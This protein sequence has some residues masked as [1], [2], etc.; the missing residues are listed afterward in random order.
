MLTTDKFK[1]FFY[2]LDLVVVAGFYVKLLVYIL[3]VVDRNL[4]GSGP[5]RAATELQLT[6][7]KLEQGR[8]LDLHSCCCL[9]LVA[10]G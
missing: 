6:E 10:G 4:Q 2:A 1:V 8:L 9:D 3:G 5:T 7:V